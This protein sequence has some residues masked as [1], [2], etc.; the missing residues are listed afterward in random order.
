MY[1]SGHSLFGKHWIYCDRA[2]MQALFRF[3]KLLKTARK[4]KKN[5]T[6][7]ETKPAVLSFLNEVAAMF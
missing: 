4:K 1:L 5:S 6:T 7:A 2:D 3:D